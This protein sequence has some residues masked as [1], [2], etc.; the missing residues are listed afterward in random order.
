MAGTRECNS[1]VT[2]GRLSKAVEFFDAAEHLED[3][4]PNA[5]GDLFVD[6]GIAA[7]DVICCVRLGVH[8]SG[9]THSEAITLLRTADS[10]SEKYLSTLLGLKNKAAY[11]SGYPIA[12]LIRT[13]PVANDAGVQAGIRPGVPTPPAITGMSPQE[14]TH[15]LFG[16]RRQLAAQLAIYAPDRVPGV[17]NEVGVEPGLRRC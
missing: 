5:A 9:G 12:V 7:S 17:I 14:V 3:E 1:V 10:G 16:F 11:T 2:A 6:A 4:M 13:H 15:A 8:S